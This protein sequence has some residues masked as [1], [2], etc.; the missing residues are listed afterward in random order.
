VAAPGGVSVD[1]AALPRLLYIGDV[2]V[3][4]TMAG[5]ALLYR[6][7]QFYPPGKL[8]LICAVRPG[9]AML[10]GVAYHHYGPMYPRLL[11]SRVAEEYV[12]WRAWRYYEVPAVIERIATLFKAQ[13]VLSIS[14]VSGWLAAWQLSKN[15][16]LP[17]HL[18]AH[19]DLVYSN[20]FPAWSRAWAERKF[21]EAYRDADS[22]FCISDA[23]EQIY[24]QR[25]GA[26][27]QVI[28]PTYKR[29]PESTAISSRAGHTASLVFGYGG[30]IN[31]A[32]DMDQLIA[33]AR[34][35][36]ARGHR[37]MV[38]S[39]QHDQLAARA[40]AA[41]VSIDTRVPV[42]SAEL[43]TRL[44]A[45]ADCLLLPQSMIDADRT[46]VATAFPTKW[47]DYSML[48]L[49]VIVWAPPGSSSERFVREH[50]G[51]AELV[52]SNDSADLERAIVQIE[53]GPEHRRRLAE[54]LLR[55]GRE[56][57]SPDAAWHKFSATIAGR[58]RA[59][60]GA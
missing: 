39:P 6:L 52:V 47:S 16:R 33:F 9:M 26:P 24:R 53:S 28:Y 43:A 32:S 55:V 36:S 1:A 3:A 38:F 46:L 29:E 2:S 34:A 7:L 19:D 41:G 35:V 21:G 23:M 27:G 31:S 50:P 10:P 14:H 51:C 11:H 4:D 22:R 25:F 56:A 8:S 57:F 20:R 60:A 37:L 42:H 45:E 5:E 44:R 49:P 17:F 15:R 59:R 54:M 30:S 48:G 12:L 58:G 40:T 18:I 13:A